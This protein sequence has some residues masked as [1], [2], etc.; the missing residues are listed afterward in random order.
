MIDFSY[1]WETTM[2]AIFPT[3]LLLFLT[4]YSFSQSNFELT[5]E[6]N[7]MSIIGQINTGNHGFVFLSYDNESNQMVLT[8]LNL[9]LKEVWNTKLNY[10]KSAGKDFNLVKLHYDGARIFVINQIK[11]AIYL[12]KIDIKNGQIEMEDEF[13]SKP[14][15]EITIDDLFISD[16]GQLSYFSKGEE[17]GLTSHDGNGE[18]VTQKDL[19]NEVISTGSFHYIFNKAS[20]SF[21]YSYS[22]NEFHTELR[23]NLYKME[24]NGEVAIDKTDTIE[25]ENHSFTYNNSINS[26]VMAF[27][28]EYD[29]FYAVGRLDYKFNRPYPK[30]KIGDGYV[31]FWIA[32]YNYNLEL[33][34]FSEI[35][36]Q[37]LKGTIPNNV[38]MKP[39]VIDLK[40]DA[41]GSTFLN[42]NELPG[43][44][45]G[46]SYLVTLDSLGVYIQ[47]IGGLDYYNF[48]EYNMTGV[49]AE[50]RKSRIRFV[51][52]EWRY[53]SVNY[54]TKIN[55]ESAAYSS[56]INELGALDKSNKKQNNEKKAYG[57]QLGTDYHYVWEYLKEKGG[58]LRCYRLKIP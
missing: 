31:G 13:Q 9:E 12:S 17:F 56:L 8:R 28:P 54:L 40:Q 51:N 24:H 1:L 33:Q 22:I 36:F 48:F 18:F 43:V 23:L 4:F 20:E 2:K 14:I 6:R 15:D 21:G 26:Q 10:T 55:Y 29:G 19:S 49:K 46:N 5:F 16:K 58:T 44:L 52:D 45:Y 30:V 38:I 37:Y 34:Y 42:I 53:Y 39:S 32:K 35:S 41:N 57:Y 47:H 7:N 25:L 11:K 3:F 27:Y 50:A